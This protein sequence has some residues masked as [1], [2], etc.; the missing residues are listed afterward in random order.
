M[1]SGWTGKSGARGSLAGSSAGSETGS[2]AAGWERRTQASVKGKPKGL[3]VKD[4]NSD[5][6]P[7]ATTRDR[8]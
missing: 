3:A 7:R 5:R 2:G 4:K 6:R 8:L 1:K